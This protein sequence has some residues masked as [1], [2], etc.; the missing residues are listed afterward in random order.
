MMGANPGIGEFWMKPP[1]FEYHD[2]GTVEEA[3][4]CLAGSI[5]QKSWQAANR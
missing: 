5:T 1:P 4:P 3:Q 2:L